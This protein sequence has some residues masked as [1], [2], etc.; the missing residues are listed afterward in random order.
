MEKAI[1]IEQNINNIRQ[2]ELRRSG[3]KKEKKMGR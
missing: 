1:N 2:I 3:M